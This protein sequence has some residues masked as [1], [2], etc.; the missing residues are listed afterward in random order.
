MSPNA[1]R[2]LVETLSAEYRDGRKP[3]KGR[4]LDQVCKITGYHLKSVIRLFRGV[5]KEPKKRPGRPRV[6][7]EGSY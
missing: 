3:E 2:E 6:Y 5:G 1:I 4:I 7:H